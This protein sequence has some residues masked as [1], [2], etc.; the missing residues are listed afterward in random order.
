MLAIFIL[1][2]CVQKKTATTPRFVYEKGTVVFE[3]TAVDVEVVDTFAKRMTGLM[4]RETLDESSGMLF[5]FDDEQVRDFWMKNTL[6]PLDIIFL[7]SNYTIV[8]IQQA[9]PCKEDPCKTY[10]SEKPSKYV[11]E[12]NLDFAKNNNI[13]E[14]MKAELIY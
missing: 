7:D 14:G 12:V 4:Y 3:N 10:S 1:S 11:V 8:K 5:I 9:V 2:S 6:I 13:T